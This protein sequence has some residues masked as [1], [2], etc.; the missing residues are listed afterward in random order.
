MTSETN[1]LKIRVFIPLKDGDIKEILIDG[2]V[3]GSPEL[4]ELI[5]E[6]D[7]KFINDEIGTHT[8]AIKFIQFDEHGEY[9]DVYLY[10]DSEIEAMKM[11]S[12]ILEKMKSL[13]FNWYYKGDISNINS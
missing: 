9:F 5:Y 2:E 11:K 6:A 8:W 13:K 10:C 12:I 7:P 3:I 1:Y 4:N